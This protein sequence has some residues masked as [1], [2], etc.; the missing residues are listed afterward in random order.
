LK[1]QLFCPVTNPPGPALCE[2]AGA[3]RD[4][5]VDN[6]YINLSSATLTYITVVLNDDECSNCPR[7]GT[8]LFRE[9]F[10]EGLSPLVRFR[11]SPLPS[12][13]YRPS[14]CKDGESAKQSTNDY[15]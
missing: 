3:T 8:D 12:N 9:L 4:V 1:Q 15:W 6:V 2:F 13:R 14:T 11:I 10:T 7:K 5:L